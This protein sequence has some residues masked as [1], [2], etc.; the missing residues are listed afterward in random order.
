M[1][2]KF[3]GKTGA[4]IKV[5]AIMYGTVV[6]AVILYGS[7]SW[8]VMDAIMAVLEGFYHRIVRRITGIT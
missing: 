6:Q 5:H 8:V 3:L 4:P 2:S 7:N 1:V